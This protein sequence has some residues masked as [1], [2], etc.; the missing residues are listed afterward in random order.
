MQVQVKLFASLARR[1]PER[2]QGEIRAG[3][4]F[5]VELPAGGRVQDL[6]RHLALPDGEV[7]VVLVNARARTPDHALSDGDEVS[8]FPLVG[9]G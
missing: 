4:P 7:K 9:G 6:L 1:G 8:I 5:P 2:I 3:Q